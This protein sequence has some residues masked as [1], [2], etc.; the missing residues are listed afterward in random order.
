MR[1]KV[2]TIFCF[3]PPIAFG[4]TFDD[5]VRIAEEAELAD[6]YK[7]YQ[8]EMY[9][10]I[11]QH[12]ANTMRG[13]FETIEDPET[14]TFY[15]VASVS[16]TGVANRIEVRPSTNISRCFAEGVEKAAFPKPPDFPDE[17]GFPVVIEMKME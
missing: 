8:Q 11:G 3:L 5:R 1:S 4:D 2:I 6:G 17:G 13:C 9:S 15:L 10:E 12:L 16:D 14:D 7:W